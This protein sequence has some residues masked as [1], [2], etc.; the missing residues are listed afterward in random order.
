MSAHYYLQVV[1]F[2]SEKQ[3]DSRVAVLGKD[4]TAAQWILDTGHV[5]NHVT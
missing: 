5:N 1:I 2:H 3:I 4:D